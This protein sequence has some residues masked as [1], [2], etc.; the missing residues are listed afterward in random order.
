MIANS[1]GMTIGRTAKAAGVP[2]TTLRYYER[3]GLLEA[4][5]RTTAGYRMYDDQ[6]VERLRF[7]RA[8]QAVG[9]TLDDI[10]KLLQLD[11]GESCGDVQ[12]LLE[13]RIGEVDRKMAELKYVRTA[14]GKALKQCEK[15][16][17]NCP[18][19]INLSAQSRR[20]SHSRQ[21]RP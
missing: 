13:R 15:S 7:I 10:R 19:L 21:A 5:V 20:A 6:A 1:Q 2:A 18:I 9:F 4:P 11:S 17:R 16:D 8:A 3:E 12:K 14:L